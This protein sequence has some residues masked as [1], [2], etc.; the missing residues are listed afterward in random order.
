MR[1]LSACLFVKDENSYLPEWIEFHRLA[2]VEH[3]YIY[4][5]GSRIPVRDTLP[6]DDTVTVIDF[7]NK[8]SQVWAYGHCATNFKGDSNWIAF[9]DADEFLFPTVHHD[10]REILPPYEKF[11][12]LGVNWLL[13]GSAGHLERPSGLQ[14]ENFQM[15]SED[16]YERNLLM[17]SIVIP[18]LVTA[19]VH[20]HCFPLQSGYMTVN[21]DFKPTSGAHSS[22]HATKKFRINHYWI[23]SK[24]EFQAKINR[25]RS[26]E[27][28]LLDDSDFLV[29][30]VSNVVRDT[31][32][33][34]FAD[35]LKEKL[36][37]YK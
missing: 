29:D 4:D 30:T 35:R 11:G 18:R 32:I 5:N 17:K 24:A 7:P 19:N 21:E 27:S 1:Y 6:A 14:I 10:L 33:L 12:G 16:S 3:F 22:P 20:T 25:G 23:R 34:R 8:G 9:I 31:T 37:R 28:R 2:G 15:R 36:E 26:D 13:F